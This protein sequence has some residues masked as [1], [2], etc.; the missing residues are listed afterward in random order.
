[1][2]N[3]SEQ[4]VVV[5]GASSGIGRETAIQFGERGARV[6]LAARNGEALENAAREVERAGGKA[7]AV[8]ADVSRW[9]DVERIAAAAIEQF[10]GIDTWVNNAGISE[11]AT[12]EDISADEMERI[13]AVNLLGEM[14]GS[15]VALEQMKKQGSGTIINIGSALSERAVPLQAAYCA[16]KHGIRGFTDALRVELHADHPGIQ[17]VLIEPSS[18]NTPLFSHARSKMGVK[19][20]PIPPIY[21]PSA[22]AQAIVHAAEHPVRDVV[23]GGS[24]KL[25]T[26]VDRISPS[27]LDRYMSQ[28]RRMFSSQKTDQ[29]DNQK[30]NLY[31]PMPGPGSVTGDFGEDSRATSVYTRAV[32]LHPERKIALTLG[33]LAATL[34]L[35]RRVGR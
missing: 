15:K 22:V 34:L 10:G 12:V 6:V 3:L 8:V 31:E 30:D 25:M 19:P 20:M 21:E 27:L 1:M 24:G 26:I 32:E 13:V 35:L 29:P 23:V 28:R 33:A 7:H 5:T 2:K 18:I 9:E 16:T 4:V 17:V 11:Y 14:Y